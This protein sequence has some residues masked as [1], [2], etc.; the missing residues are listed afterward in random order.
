VRK[1]DPA[2]YP[3]NTKWSI[4]KVLLFVATV[5]LTGLS[6]AQPKPEE[7]KSMNVKRITPV[8]FVKE[9]EPC[10]TFWVE[11][12]GFQKTAEVPEGDRLGFVILTKGNTEIM[13]QSY[14]SAEKDA[15]TV[16]KETGEGRTF[17]YI[18]VDKLDE[19]I[20]AMKGTKV[21]V[22]LRTTFY[23]AKEIVVKEPAG[24]VVVFAEMT[25]SQQH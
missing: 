15:P 18:E 20:S 13:Y 16:A 17:L 24:H 8:L 10:V 21:V 4:N 9:I 14:A 7:I 6:T 22:P 25:G 5:V 11:R 3:P 23:G 12:L 1:D 19:V 2:D